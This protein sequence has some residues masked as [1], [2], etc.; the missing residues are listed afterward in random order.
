MLVAETIHVWQNSFPVDVLNPPKIRYLHA[1]SKIRGSWPQ[2]LLVDSRSLVAFST[3]SHH[4]Y[5]MGP[6][7]KLVY[8]PHEYY[9]Y[10]VRFIYHKPSSWA[11]C[12]ATERYLG[13]P[14]LWNSRISLNFPGIPEISGGFP[15]GFPRGF[16]VWPRQGDL[17]GTSASTSHCLVGLHLGPTFWRGEAQRRKGPLFGSF[18]LGK[19]RENQGKVSTNWWLEDYSRHTHLKRIGC[20]WIWTIRHVTWI[21]KSNRIAN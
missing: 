15:H 3:N 4:Q 8:K 10:L 9:R 13:G 16:L 1:G 21:C 19:S 5:R 7:Y 18:F 11:T 20:W 6:S 2:F 12:K 14:I 17:H